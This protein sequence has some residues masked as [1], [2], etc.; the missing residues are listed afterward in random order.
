[1]MHEKQIADALHEL[2]TSGYSNVPGRADAIGEL[3]E[4][5]QAVRATGTRLWLDTGDID[6][7][8][9]LW[10]PAFEALTTNNT[11]LNREVQKGLYDDFVGEAASTIRAVAPAL[12]RKHLLLEIAFALNA[13]HG[14][15]LVERFDANV[16]VELHTDLAHDVERTIAYGRRF[17]SICPERFYIKIPLSLAG[18][19]AARRLTESG[20]PINLTLG[21]S[22]RQNV[23]TAL[24]AKTAFVNVFMGRLSAFV[25]DNALGDGVNVGE[26]ATLATQ[27]ELLGLREAGMTETRL[28]GASMRTGSQ[29]GTL[30]GLDVFTMPPKVA[31]QYLA[32]PLAAVRTR[33]S[34]APVVTMAEGVTLDSLA[35]STLWD[36]PIE[37]RKVAE[38]VAQIDPG[39][40]TPEEISGRLERVGIHDLFPRWSE[41]EIHT[42]AAD[43]K[44]PV[45]E[46]WK[47]QLQ[48][49]QVGLDAL[50]NLSAFL[51]FAADQAA[52]D[53]RTEAHLG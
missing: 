3:Q 26:K 22:A 33:I 28:I 2:V 51:S 9:E 52:L 32:D 42:A 11:L 14:L 25:A 12:D 43:G 40:L 31:R 46:H 6:E 18:L 34:D 17:Y 35:A 44:I 50:M 23:L 53:S 1:M 7:A 48:S 47:P 13:R 21:F 16:S 30:A 39:L 36:V 10:N 15:A 20:I 27:R 29:V 37:F 38:E 49:G 8:S 45:Y 4:S 19:V 5:W 24:V 41:N